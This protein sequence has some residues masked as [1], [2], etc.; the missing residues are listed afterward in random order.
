MW[1]STTS[2]R[3]KSKT[4]ANGAGVEAK[5][6]QEEFRQFDV[7][8]DLQRR[9]QAYSG[10]KGSI[11]MLK[12]VAD[13]YKRYRASVQYLM[14]D[15]KRD[16]QL[17][18]HICGVVANLVHV[19]PRL[20]MAMEVALGGRLQNIVTENEGD[21]KYLIQYLKDHDYGRVTFCP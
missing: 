14:Q 12:D 15:A 7:N 9:Q 19:E 13:N 11:A 16:R 8:K 5:I 3:R 21:V 10:E 20:Q 17:A 2:R 1:K 6:K 18:S 4:S